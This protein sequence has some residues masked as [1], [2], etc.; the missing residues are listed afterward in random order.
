MSALLRYKLNRLPKFR[1][2]VEIYTRALSESQL[3]SQHFL[4]VSILFRPQLLFIFDHFLAWWVVGSEH[5]KVRSFRKIRFKV[6][7]HKQECN[8]L[9]GKGGA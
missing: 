2:E 7:K 4:R 9:F 6:P 8:K 3:S 5:L 1:T